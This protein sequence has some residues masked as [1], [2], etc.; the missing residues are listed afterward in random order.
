MYMPIFVSVLGKNSRTEHQ[1]R[2]EKQGMEGKDYRFLPLVPMGSLAINTKLG[3][4][5]AVFGITLGLSLGV[6]F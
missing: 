4:L 6:D 2:W 5:I 1:F 3:V